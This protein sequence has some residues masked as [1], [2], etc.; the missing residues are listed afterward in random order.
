MHIN[1]PC[2]FSNTNNPLLILNK[3]HRCLVYWQIWILAPFKQRRQC[4]AIALVR[5]YNVHAHMHTVHLVHVYS[6][7]TLA[8]SYT[9][10][11]WAGAW[12]LYF[13]DVTSQQWPVWSGAPFV[14]LFAPEVCSFS[15]Q[16]FLFLAGALPHS[17]AVGRAPWNGSLL[18]EWG[19][20][21]WPPLRWVQS[22]RQY[23]VV[24]VPPLI[25][26]ELSCTS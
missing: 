18:L 23:V 1:R 24:C 9:Y 25:K 7:R 14:Q 8:S 3:A 26:Q 11:W 6:T 15:G 16:V 12:Y 4:S 20:P 2:C 5:A 19:W 22:N 13:C 21:V 10:T 17:W